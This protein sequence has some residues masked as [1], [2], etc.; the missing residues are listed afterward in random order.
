MTKMLIEGRLANKPESNDGRYERLESPFR[1]RIEPRADA[2]FPAEHGRYHLYIST[3]CPWCHRATLVRAL[4]GLGDAITTTEMAVVMGEASWAI[5][6]ERFDPG[7]GVPQDRFMHEVYVRADPRYTGPITVPVL[8]DKRDG[9]IVSNESADI[10]RMLGSAFE[11]VE[12]NDLDLY[13]EPLRGEIDSWNE[14][15]HER[16]NSGV[17]RAGFAGTQSAYDEAALAVFEALETLESHL[18]SRSHLVGDRLT[19]PDLRLYTTLVRFDAAY[20]THFKLDRARIVDY[21]NLQTLL[22]SVHVLP[23]VAATMDTQR[24]R[25]HYFLSHP[26]LNPTGIVSLG[27]A[28]LPAI[29]D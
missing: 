29:G 16:I 13:P 1:H 26:A 15:V 14:F 4:K 9:T 27:P 20:A 23:G 28:P 24:M 3:A 18:A 2:R 21:P 22:E 10:M 19:E 17:Y 25:A 11:G 12:G 5:D 8:W 6:P 7:A